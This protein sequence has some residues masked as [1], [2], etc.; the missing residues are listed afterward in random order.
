[1]FILNLVN[2]E[3]ER[4]GQKITSNSSK[5]PQLENQIEDNDRNTNQE[6][7][8]SKVIFDPNFI[9]EMSFTKLKKLK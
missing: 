8:D 1:M 4:K 7:P 2:K 5:F 3:K 6:K 9:S